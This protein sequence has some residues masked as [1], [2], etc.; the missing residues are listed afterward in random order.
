MVAMMARTDHA[1]FAERYGP[2]ALVTGAA[3][4]VGLA[5]AQAL[6]ERGLSVVL[7]DR[8]PTVVEVARS[9]GGTAIVTD[10]AEPGW[11]DRIGDSGDV[12]V[13]VA[14]AATGHVGRFLD[15]APQKWSEMIAVNCQA[16]VDLAAWALPP[17]VDRGRGALLITSSGSALAGSVGLAVYSATKAFLLNLAES[18]AVEVGDTGVDVQ[19]LLG[20]SMDTPGFRA[21]EPDYDAMPVPPVD[22]GIVVER[23]LD[24][25][26]GET[27]VHGDEGLAFLSTMTRPDRVQVMSDVGRAMYPHLEISP[28]Q[29]Q[30]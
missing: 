18:L 27:V 2:V 1:A 8:D 12:G 20:P 24:A 30:A 6:T 15:G 22:P 10:V 29:R 5:Y 4:G 16:T 11:L 3:H 19:V 14:N 26:G 9:L 21:S 28:D 23:A 25:L 7:V 13:V 17:M